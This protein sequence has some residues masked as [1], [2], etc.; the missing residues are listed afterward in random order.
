[1]ARETGGKWR[2]REEWGRERDEEREL[3]GTGRGKGSMSEI[4]RR[5]G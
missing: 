4:E 5:G 3:R 2:V 1:M